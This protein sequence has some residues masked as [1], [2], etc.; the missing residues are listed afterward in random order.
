MGSEDETSWRRQFEDMGVNQVRARLLEWIGPLKLSA[1]RWLAEKDQDATRLAEASMSEQMEIARSAKDAA[2]EAN[3]LA[4]EANSIARE[5][6]AS[7]R[8]AADAA[9]VNAHA[10]RTNNIIATLAIIAATIAIA[11]SII[12]IFIGR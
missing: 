10:A 1:T 3:K 5:A 9:V 6:A 12:G 2:F 7:A 4:S 8:A 11:I